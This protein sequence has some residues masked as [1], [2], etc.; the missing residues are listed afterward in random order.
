[1]FTPLP[2]VEPIARNLQCQA[3]P[4]SEGDVM[5]W[6]VDLYTEARGEADRLP[7]EPEAGWFDRWAR[8][9]RFQP[10]IKP[11]WYKDFPSVVFVDSK[12][13]ALLD[14]IGIGGMCVSEKF[15]TA[16]ERFE[17]GVHD[18]LPLELR[19]GSRKSYDAHQYYYF[20][21][22]RYVTSINAERSNLTR[23]ETKIPGKGSI[24]LLAKKRNLPVVV[25]QEAVAGMH[26]W[27]EDGP[28]Q[29]VGGFFI[30]DELYQAFVECGLSTDL[31]IEEQLTS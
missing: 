29:A 8:Q 7:D 31:R 17:P 14:V 22:C 23:G 15:R 24:P 9:D 21:I 30:S 11:E 3:P 16:V 28:V 12:N 10:K 19:Y 26:L 20:H 1:M 4:E 6:F 18:F 25:N 27:Q 13:T 5:V 2:P